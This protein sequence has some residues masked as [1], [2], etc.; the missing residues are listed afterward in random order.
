M[1]YAGTASRA[2]GH[3]T[4]A[5]AAVCAALM[6]CVPLAQAAPPAWG[7]PGYDGGL[8]GY[9]PKGAPITAGNA[10]TLAPVW[11]IAIPNLATEG[12]VVSD[13]LLITAT[14]GASPG[15]VTAWRL[16]DGTLAW[17]KDVSDSGFVAADDG[18]VFASVTDAPPASP[19][20]GVV[21][22]DPATGTELWRRK[23]GELAPL[24][25]DH[26][27]LFTLESQSQTTIA[28]REK[29]GHL[30]WRAEDT[31]VLMVGG[32]IVIGARVQSGRLTGL[33]ELGGYPYWVG[34][35]FPKGVDPAHY[36]E[37]A[38]SGALMYSVVGRPGCPCRLSAVHIRTG[39]RIW[40]AEVR[41]HPTDGVAAGAGRTYE[42]GQRPGFPDHLYALDGAG[43][44]VWMTPGGLV[45]P[46]KPT[47]T[48]HL[49]FAVDLAGTGLVAFKVTNGRQ[50]AHWPDLDPDGMLRAPMVIGDTL[51][52]VG[53]GRLTALRLPPG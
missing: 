47:I 23:T 45:S 4:A 53:S 30:L 35:S 7:Q 20:T 12:A 32:G 1:R 41:S 17:S 40:D 15:H 44:I 43:R 22:L 19:F 25:A 11:S 38:L 8:S 31:R 37:L 48:R 14:S 42:V 46:M 18:R 9:T 29:T 26:G 10:A 34:R 36:D 24:R 13:G 39:A 21:R 27:R 16:T 33:N 5:G 6:L 49:V 2:A 52:A 50:V 28:I 3:L 51:V